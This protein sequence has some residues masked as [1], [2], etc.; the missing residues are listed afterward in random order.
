MAPSPLGLCQEMWPLEHVHVP[1]TVR[2][3]PGGQHVPI[4]CLSVCEVTL[5]LI[6]FKMG[7]FNIEQGPVVETF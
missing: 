1:H 5:S 3:L 7:P 2:T 4:G 6:G